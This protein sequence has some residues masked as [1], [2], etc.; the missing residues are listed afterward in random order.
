MDVFA[1]YKINE[2]FT[3]SARIENLFDQFY[4]DPLSLVTQPG[5]GRTFFASLTA[6][7]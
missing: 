2:H 4:V 7:F 6:K 5:P 3:A 1:E